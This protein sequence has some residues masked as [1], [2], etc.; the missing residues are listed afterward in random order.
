M[1]IKQGIWK[2]C[3]LLTSALDGCYLCDIIT[4]VRI[5]ACEI[6]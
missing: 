2:I 6:I 5:A 4:Y 1:L 3:F